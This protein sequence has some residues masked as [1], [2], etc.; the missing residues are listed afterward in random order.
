MEI[1][2]LLVLIVALFALV[3]CAHGSSPNYNEEYWP[4][5]DWKDAP[6]ENTLGNQV[7]NLVKRYKS[8]QF[9]GLMGR[10][11]G[12]PLPG[13]LGRKRNKG[14][15]FVGLMGRRSSSGELEDEWDKPQFY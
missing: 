14:E 10:R 11:S 1:W 7:T 15:A 13:R 2:K 6:S 4:T 5:E 9:Y 3:Y 8:Q 12:V